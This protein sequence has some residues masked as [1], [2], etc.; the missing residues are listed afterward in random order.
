MIFIFISFFWATLFL[1]IF[2]QGQELGPRFVYCK[3][4][5]VI[6]TIRT[7]DVPGDGCKAVYTKAGI[8]RD[9]GKGKNWASCEKV[10]DNI[11][12]NL[13]EAAWRCREFFGVQILKETLKKSKKEKEL[14]ED[15][16]RD[17]SL[18]HI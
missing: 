7:V 1:P 2:G 8:D 10:I 15:L 11:R 5:E 16:S 12:S 9:V 13:E 4:G 18:I 6:R 17:L 3:L 14:K